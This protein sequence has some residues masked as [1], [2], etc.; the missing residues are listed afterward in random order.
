MG[1]VG[2]HGDADHLAVALSEFFEPMIKGENL[3]RAD[4]GEVEGIKEQHDVSPA[5]FLK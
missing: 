2:V 3:G 1:E 5:V 4:E